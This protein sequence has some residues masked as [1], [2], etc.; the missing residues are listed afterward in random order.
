MIDGAR[1][2]ACTSDDSLS[3]TILLAQ[4]LLEK[5]TS[6]YTSVTLGYTQ[7]NHSYSGSLS[8]AAKPDS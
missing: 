3:R 5:Y 2:E 7:S 8:H 6:V 1:K 4:T